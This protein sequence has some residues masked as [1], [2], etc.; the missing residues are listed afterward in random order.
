MLTES[1]L[2]AN[3]YFNTNQLKTVI[4]KLENLT[5]LVTDLKVE[6]QS[7]PV[8]PTCNRLLSE[9]DHNE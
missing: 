5:V 1:E 6:Q 2:I 3:Y 7:F 8:C 9:G 4:E